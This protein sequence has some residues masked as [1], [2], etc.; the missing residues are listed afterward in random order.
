M[1]GGVFVVSG[2]GD[3]DAEDP[4]APVADHHGVVH[5]DGAGL[6]VAVQIDA[7]Q[8]LSRLAVQQVHVAAGGAVELVGR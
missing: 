7:V 8:L 3:P 1:I 2:S 4:L 6:D 5:H